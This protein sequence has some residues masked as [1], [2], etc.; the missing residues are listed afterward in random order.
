MKENQERDTNG[1]FKKTRPS[2]DELQQKDDNQAK[3]LELANA[4][5][6]NIISSSNRKEKVI[7]TLKD[8]LF[9]TEQEKNKAQAE[10]ED[11]RTKM[12]RLRMEMDSEIDVYKKLLSGASILALI[13]FTLTILLLFA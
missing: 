6:S 9:K 2:Y 8:Q 11:L 13:F 5:R 7:L 10:L 3:Q 12:A 1:R 4:E